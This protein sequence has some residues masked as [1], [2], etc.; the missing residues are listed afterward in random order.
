MISTDWVIG[1][2]LLALAC[3]FGGIAIGLR[4]YQRLIRRID[5]RRAR[6]L[7]I[8]LKAIRALQFAGH[9]ALSTDDRIDALTSARRRVRGLI[10]C[11]EEE[12]NS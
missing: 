9:T 10:S 8:D 4:S 11:L 7:L 1:F 6:M 3:L 2:G 12:V 5:R